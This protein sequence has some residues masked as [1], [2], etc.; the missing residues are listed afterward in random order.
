MHGFAIYVST[1]TSKKAYAWI[2][3]LFFYQ[4]NQT[5]NL[6]MD[7][8][9]V[10]SKT[11]KKATY[12]CMDSPSILGFAIY[13]STKMA[14]CLLCFHKKHKKAAYASKRQPMHGLTIYFHNFPPKQPKGHRCMDSPSI[15][16]PKQ[17]KRPPMHG[18]AIYFSTKTT[19]KSAYAWIRHV[20]FYQNNP[21]GHLCMDSPSIF[22]PKQ[23]K[24]PPMHG[25][26]M[27]FS[28]KTT[29]QVTYA[30]IRHRFFYQNNHLFLPKQPKRPPM[31]GYFS[32]NQPMHGF[33]IYFYTKTTKKAAYAWMKIGFLAKR[34]GFNLDKVP[35]LRGARAAQR[36]AGRPRLKNPKTAAEFERQ[37]TSTCGNGDKRGPHRVWPKCMEGPL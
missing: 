6:C 35:S 1:K 5:G 14:A 34:P 13:F 23:P 18:F 11:T 15:L 37:S 16:L 9:Y 12:E 33:A 10:S 8:I 28:T 4:N 20:F 7:S 30:W 21:Q 17:P 27:Y 2:R 36:P 22:L 19:K 32:T 3:H 25:F 26:A 29:Q 31:H 24:S